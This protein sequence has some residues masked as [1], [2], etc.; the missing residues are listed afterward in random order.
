MESLYPRNRH[1]NKIQI[2]FLDFK[3]SKWL[4]D[5]TRLEVVNVLEEAKHYLCD[6]EDDEIRSVLIFHFNRLQILTDFDPAFMLEL[7]L[8]WITR[9]SRYLSSDA[10]HTG[11]YVRHTITQCLLENEMFS[12]QFFEDNVNKQPDL[13][14]GLPQFEKMPDWYKYGIIIDV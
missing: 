14:E 9:L 7:S 2:E 6:P 3:K 4:L 5:S 10:F 1:C 11:S 13:F 12:K 8:P